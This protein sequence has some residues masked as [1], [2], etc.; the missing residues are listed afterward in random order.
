MPVANVLRI[1]YSGADLYFS[2]DEVW[3]AT[4]EESRDYQIQERQSG[5]PKLK[6]I[7]DL[8]EA[9]EIS[10]NLARSGTEMKIDQFLESGEELEIFPALLRD[11]SLSFKCVPIRDGATKRYI[12]GESA[13]WID[14][15]ISF[16]KSS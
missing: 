15:T 13:A 5:K 3:S 4:I 14:K 2:A 6:I 16:L 8:I 11:S 7:G 10:F 12:Y 1:K 9:L